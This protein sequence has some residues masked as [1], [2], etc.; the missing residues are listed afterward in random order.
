[1][2]L[3]CANKLLE[4]LL[5]LQRVQMLSNVFSVRERSVFMV[6]SEKTTAAATVRIHDEFCTDPTSGRISHLSQIVS[7][8]YKRRAMATEMAVPAMATNLEKEALVS[9]ENIG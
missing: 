6:V 9:A 2:N 5:D 3:I 8:S 1:M 4:S 7:N